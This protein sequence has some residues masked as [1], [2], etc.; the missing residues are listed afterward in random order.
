MKNVLS[1][2]VAAAVLC[3][4]GANAAVSQS[5]IDTLKAQMAEMAARLNALEHENHKL[6]EKA[7]QHKAHGKK[8]TA[9]ASWTDNIKLKGDLRYRYENI[10]KEGSDTRNRNRVRARAQLVAKLPSDVEVGIGV[11]SGSADPASSNQTLGGGATS[12]DLNLDLAYFKWN[13]NEQFNLTGGKYKSQWFKPQKSSL[14]YDG[15]LRPEGF[16]LGFDNG[17]LFAN[18]EANW[19]E[20]DSKK[21]DELAYSAQLGF[22]AGVVTAAVGYI[23]IPVKGSA[24]LYKG[25]FYGNSSVNGV[26]AYD[27][28]LANVAINADLVVRGLPFAVYADFVQNQDAGSYDTG[29]IVGAK[30]GKAK[31]PGTWQLQYQY[32]DLEA[33]AVLGVWTDSDF[34]GGDTDGKGHK[35]SGKYALA[36]Q[37][38]VGLTY[39]INEVGVDLGGSKDYDRVQVDTVFKF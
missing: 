12:K 36:K 31:H 10:D 33:D 5:D 28:E 25:D 7:A 4:A 32:Q 1:A 8:H 34:A 39:L 27:Y 23:N 9:G 3:S 38:T 29:Y 18:V 19:I 20:S 14:I 26:Y 21:G 6:R 2:A 24:P 35:L 37:W 22:K 30:L 15:D 16:A 11:A 13:I 17:N